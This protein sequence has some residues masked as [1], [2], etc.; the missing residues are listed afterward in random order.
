VKVG[1]ARVALSLA[2]LAGSKAALGGAFKN[3][4]AA[5]IDRQRLICLKSQREAATQSF[6]TSRV[7]SKSAWDVFSPENGG[8]Y[9]IE[10][11]QETRFRWSEPAAIMS[12]WMNEGRHRI[13]MECGPYRPLVHAGLRFYVN[14]RPLPAQDVSIGLDT[15]DIT[16]DL[17][18]SGLC[19]LGW[20]CLRFCAKGEPRWLGLP[21]KRII[22][23]PGT[24][25]STWKT[26]AKEL[27]LEVS[28]TLVTRANEMIE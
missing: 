19:T 18:Q 23:K 16:F 20:T 21:I 3:H 14:E 2:S 6:V 22:R 4:V 8:F 28:P 10:T 5:L 9:P 1:L 7:D 17:A 15:I 25:S 26:T 13:R 24:E 27:G 12:A 11:D